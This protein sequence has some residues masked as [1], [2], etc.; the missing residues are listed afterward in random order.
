MNLSSD[1]PLRIGVLGAA[2]IARLFAEAVRAV[3]QGRGDRRG[4]PGRRL[5]RPRSRAI[6]VSQ[7]FTRPTK[8]CST[9]PKSTRSTCRC[10]TTCTP[11]GRFA[12]LRRASTC[13]ARSRSRLTAAEA[14]A[15]FDAARQNG[16][17]VVEAYPYRAQPQTLKMRELLAAKAIGSVAADSGVIRISADGRG[18]YP[19]EPG[20]RGRSADGC[21]LVS[22]Q[23]CPHWWPVR[24]RPAC[25]RDVAMGR[26]RA[27]I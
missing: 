17:Y 16:V 18:E 9:I 21:R 10:P 4:E 1:R 22:G 14:R 3:A 6:P 12:P 20:P 8:R 24:S 13:C 5:A 2:K 15:M 27:W 26:L 19:D 23:P 11:R 7:R 25:S